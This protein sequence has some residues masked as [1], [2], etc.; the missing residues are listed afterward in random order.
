VLIRNYI[1]TKLVSWK[2][3]PDQYYVCNRGIG[4]T[5]IFLSMMGQYYYK[6]Q[7]KINLI[8]PKN[9][10]VLLES[11]RQ[12]INKIIVLDTKKLLRLISVLW[13]KEKKIDHMKFI[14]PPKAFNLLNENTTLFDLI[15]K[16]IGVEGK[17]FIAPVFKW[18]ENRK[19]EVYQML[20]IAKDKFVIIAPMSESLKMIDA[21]F[22]V[23]VVNEYHK[24][25]YLVL[26]NGCHGEK[27]QYGDKT[28]F[29]S[30]DEMYLLAEEAKEICC[31]RSGLADLLSFGGS[32]KRIIYSNVLEYKMFCINRMPFAQNVTE[33]II[34][35]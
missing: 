35:E 29:L 12:Y 16:E 11:Y 22:W 24:N 5:I 2:I 8:I 6:N 33:E 7:K 1:Y 32:H 13:D 34:G 18:Q 30:L 28:I 25:G 31:A 19:Y 17:E 21:D 14:L 26:E 10:Q 27:P 20:G 23:T 15:G 3:G 4:D 9:Q